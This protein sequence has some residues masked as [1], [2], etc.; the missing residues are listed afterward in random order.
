MLVMF[1]SKPSISADLLRLR[2]TYVM[3]TKNVINR[4][5]NAESVTG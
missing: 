5:Y 2:P 3:I 4:M 1:I